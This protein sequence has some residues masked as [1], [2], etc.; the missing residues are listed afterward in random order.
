M[1][2]FHADAYPIKLKNKGILKNWL[3]KI[4]GS[5]G[6]EVKDLNFIFLTD[7]ALYEMNV[8]YLNHDT[9]TDIITF[10]NSDEEKVIEGDIFIS[11]D[12]IKENAINLKVKFETELMR[13][14][15]HGLLHLCGYGDKKVK[16]IELMRQKE[17]EAI[18]LFGKMIL[19]E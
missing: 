14:I 19:S 7:E 18:A 12:R 16:E 2:T 9:Y 13:V 8:Q 4:A 10:D 5:E 11:V 6:F 17:N 3:K 15:S 1:I